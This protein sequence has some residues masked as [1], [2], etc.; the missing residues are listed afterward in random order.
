MKIGV[1]LQDWILRAKARGKTESV[2]EVEIAFSR[3]FEFI[4]KSS[5]IQNMM[6][7]LSTFSDAKAVPIEALASVFRITLTRKS[8]HVTEMA[9]TSSLKSHIRC[10][11]DACCGSEQSAH[12]ADFREC[13]GQDL[14]TMLQE[15][16]YAL[17]SV[18]QHPTLD[19]DSVLKRASEVSTSLWK[20]H[21]LPAV[22]REK[23]FLKVRHGHCMSLA[24]IVGHL[25]MVSGD[26]DALQK[27]KRTHSYYHNSATLSISNILSIQAIRHRL[28][29]LGMGRQGDFIRCA[30]S[31]LLSDSGAALLLSWTRMYGVQSKKLL[32]SHASCL[33]VIIRSEADSQVWSDVEIFADEIR[34]GSISI[35]PPHHTNTFREC[36]QLYV[37]AS[38]GSLSV[39]Y[40]MPVVRACRVLHNLVCK[41]FLDLSIISVDH[42]LLVLRA[43][44]YRYDSC[45]GKLKSLI[46]DVSVEVS[47]PVP[48]AC[49]ECSESSD[50][51]VYSCPFDA[52]CRMS[53]GPNLCT[54]STLPVEGPDS[55]DRLLP[56]RFVPPNIGCCI[57]AVPAKQRR[58]EYCIVSS[59]AELTRDGV[60]ISAPELPILSSD[61]CSRVKVRC[62]PDSAPSDHSLTQ[63]VSMAMKALCGY[64]S[65]VSDYELKKYGS[66]PD[67]SVECKTVYRHRS[68]C[69]ALVVSHLSSY[70]VGRMTF[71][72]LCLR[73]LSHMETARKLPPGV[74]WR[75]LANPA[76]RKS[77]APETVESNHGM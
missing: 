46:M 61:V 49:F 2:M 26:H 40:T 12:C 69:N 37:G 4:K 33:E 76:K 53:L 32:V 35:Q 6:R 15:A 10:I 42:M 30:A 36:N 51:D 38:L 64:A 21:A 34:P 41:G 62:A 50:E 7:T 16:P 14:E 28:D 66:K 27:I 55:S 19:S 58:I 8:T 45:I 22:Q 20:K 5:K 43:E 65:I 29:A 44:R 48:E 70:T 3:L 25:I 57:T 63:K 74:E 59:I 1:E 24:S 23:E 39:F 31:S 75:R 18:L 68:R 17:W 72:S 71:L 11:S 13:H 56:P 77:T 67:L 73:V 60:S 54:E 52:S 47:I 9:I